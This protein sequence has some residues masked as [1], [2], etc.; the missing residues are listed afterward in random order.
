MK[1]V[2]TQYLCRA[3]GCAQL[4]LLLAP[5]V[6]TS[7]WG[8]VSHCQFTLA[9]EHGE[10][11]L[12]PVI[13][14]ALSFKGATNTQWKHPGIQNTVS[15]PI[16]LS[17]LPCLVMKIQM[18]GMMIFSGFIFKL[19]ERA[20]PMLSKMPRDLLLG[21]GKRK[22][23]MSCTIDWLLILEPICAAQPVSYHY[24]RVLGN[25]C[26]L[27]KYECSVSVTSAR[28]CLPASTPLGDGV[29]WMQC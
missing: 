19:L 24:W 16:H 8:K 2:L 18:V 20:T 23:T 6:S 14:C 25:E 9:L 4:L 26:N 1:K 11:T 27:Y 15:E 7:S 21:V 17:Q 3:L 10:E 22:I 5:E 28:Q 12:I 13:I 29:A